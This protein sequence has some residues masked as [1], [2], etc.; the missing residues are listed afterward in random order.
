[1]KGF[2]AAFS[3]AIICMAA[4]AL[5][6]FARAQGSLLPLPEEKPIKGVNFP[7][8]SP[9]G[10]TLCFSY[11]GDLWSVASAGGT[12]TRLTVHEAHD[13]YPHYS[14]DGKWIAF[15]SNRE[16][17][18]DVF[19][20]S[21]SGGSA[22][23]LT[24]NSANDYA[25]DWSP[26]G[27][28]ILFYSLR[29]TETWQLYSL[30]V[31][32]GVVK[33]LTNDDQ[34]LRYGAYSPD[35]TSVAYDR[36]GSVGTWWRPRYHGS[37]NMEIYSKSL[38]TGK[39]TRVTDYDGTDLWPMYSGDGKSIYYVSDRLTTG[40]PNVVVSPATGGKPTLVTKYK[41]DAVRWPAMA[42]DGSLIAYIYGGE[43]WTVKPNGGAPTKPVIYALSDDKTN[44][45]TR[46]NLTN[47]ATEVEVSPDGKT[48]ALVIR[49]ELWTIPSNT[50]G[51]A[52][53]LTN[54]TAHDYDIM[55]SP[56]SKK[57]AFVSDRNGNF[58]VFTID[59]ATKEVKQVTS[60]GN[61]ETNPHYS[62]DGK[63]LAF[64][65]SGTQGGIYVIPAD[66]SAAP[67]RVV[68][69]LGNN[70]EFGVGINS[71][72]WSPDGKWMSFSRRDAISSAD[73]W[74]VPVAG[75]KAVNVTY[76]PG[77]NEDALWT[78]D[79]KYLLF[80][81]DRE[82]QPDI[83]AIPLVR[84]KENPDAPATPDPN[85]KPA[86]KKPLD[87]KID[88][89]D[90][91]NRAKRVTTMGTPAFQLTPDGK[92]AIF[93][94]AAA[95]PPEYYGVPV[96]GGSPQRMTGSG[97]GTGAPRFATDPNT[98][99]ALGLGGTVKAL[100]H[101]GPIWIPQA[102]AFSGR[103]EFDRRA[104]IRETFNEF[105]RRLNVGFYDPNMH[106][107]DWRAIR[108]R[109]EPLLEGV[110]TKEEFAMYLLS[111]MVGELNSSHS[112]PS[113]APGPPGSQTA[114]LGMTFDENYTGPGLKV[115]GFMPKGP[116]DDLGP[117]IKPGEYILSIDGD[118]VS[119]KETLYLTLADKAGKTVELL[120]NSTP[121]KDG[122]RTVKLKPITNTEWRNLEY[123]RKVTVA[124]AEVDKL[125]GGRLAYIHIKGMDQPSL[126]RM[127]RELWGKARDKDALVLD[128]RNNGGGNTHDAILGE[129]SRPVYG[130]EQ[131][132]DGP[133][134]TQP[135]RT[136][137][138]PIILLMNQN[139]VSDAEIFPMGFRNLKLGKIVGVATPGYVI[140]T[141]EGT[142]Q[143]GTGYRIPMW[144]WYT[145]DGKDM[146]NNGVKPDINVE[147]TTED[148][149]A[150]RDRQLEVAIDTL[151]KDLPKAK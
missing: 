143:D 51:D 104:E 46:L 108:T 123:E 84:E 30:D 90:I 24:F 148:I 103:M 116:D 34:N 110:A 55:W 41:S 144:G 15:S 20:I 70:L 50:G 45:I 66:G 94:A 80:I 59:P 121:S 145:Q 98:F 118:D 109:Y 62:P 18:Y 74:V 72:S 54:T 11:L 137:G 21:S 112:E 86:D 101:L 128:I 93:V 73:V 117:R 39:I 9:D 49:G 48:L 52:K 133:R 4:L 140:G 149:A 2:R 1:M 64:L 67:R 43:L 7:A 10:K 100:R 35:G 71:Y 122:A 134:I 107:V 125:S 65:R 91:E 44:N 82:R 105:W 146:E 3:A 28:K 22:R 89:D 77:T 127:E 81:S 92:T 150:K 38:T 142:L 126:R 119:W 111:P 36:C 16:G 129:I 138:K 114:E 106:G 135:I 60:D 95:G 136:F 58:D 141:Y 68:E 56:D 19:L 53:R 57:L 83:Y 102:I 124:R 147:M 75:G 40:T 88:F 13:G 97:E 25:M 131:P 5:A 26:D 12:A 6:P 115:T 79:G 113:P 31:A 99:Y 14:P 33:T 139:S 151:L 63:W 69:S 87:V 96:A 29:G 76:T 27:T 37:A 85:A 130:Y 120:V 78:S 61:D 17:N 42:H 23:Q 32:T 132:R 47:G 8:V